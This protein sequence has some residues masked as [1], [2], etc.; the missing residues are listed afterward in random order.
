MEVT[1]MGSPIRVHKVGRREPGEANVGCDRDAV[2]ICY[3]EDTTRPGNHNINGDYLATLL[4]KHGFEVTAGDDVSGTPLRYLCIHK[5]DGTA[6]R[7]EIVAVLEQDPEID[8][9]NIH[10]REGNQGSEQSA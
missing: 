5:A 8:L 9:T 7:D 6:T 4:N 1:I 10:R 3:K 2:Q